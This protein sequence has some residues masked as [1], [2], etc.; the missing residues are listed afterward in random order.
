MFPNGARPA[1]IA[2]GAV[3]GGYEALLALIDHPANVPHLKLSSS[4]ALVTS[5]SKRSNF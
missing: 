3:N 2:G 4:Y 5:L 1:N